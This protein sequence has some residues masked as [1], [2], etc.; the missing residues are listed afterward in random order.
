MPFTGHDDRQLSETHTTT[1]NP[2]TTS[3]RTSSALFD[4]TALKLLVE[5][6]IGSSEISENMPAGLSLNQTAS[7]PYCIVSLPVSKWCR[8]S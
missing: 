2:S 8:Q 1:T 6:K 4:E 3:S 7:P 5:G